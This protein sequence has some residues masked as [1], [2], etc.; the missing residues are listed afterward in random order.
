MSQKRNPYAKRLNKDPVARMQIAVLRMAGCSSTQI[1][2][3]TG[4]H[5]RTIIK[6]LRRDE[7]K[8]IFRN[9][10]SFVGKKKLPAEAQAVIEKALDE[11]AGAKA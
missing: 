8:E 3:S 5:E 10:V 7:H 9:C 4:R 1:A 11:K 6:E 2:E